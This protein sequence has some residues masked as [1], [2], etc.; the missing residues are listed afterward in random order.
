MPGSLDRACA[1]E[2]KNGRCVLHGDLKTKTMHSF[3]WKFME[4]GGYHFGQLVVQVV[5][6][7]LLSPSDSGMLAIILVFINIGSVLV[8]SGLNTALVQA[9]HINSKD[10]STVFWFSLALAGLLY[11]LLYV[12]AP[13]AALWYGLPQLT[14]ALRVLGLVLFIGAFNSIQIA[15]ASRNLDFRPIFESTSAAVALSGLTGIGMA[16]LGYGYWALIG[17]QLVYGTIA[18]LVLSFKFPWIP[19][20]EFDLARGKQFY[21]YGWKLA[22]SSLLDTAFS[23]LYDLVVG[24]VFSRATLGYFAQ[25]EK[26]PATVNALFDGSIQSVMLSTM[27]KLQDDTKLAK[28]ALRRS[29]SLSTF[30]VVPV[31]A[32]L[33]LTAPSL[34]V[35]VLSA[36]WVDSVPFLQAFCVLYAVQPIHVADGPIL[37]T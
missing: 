37:T 25:G 21:R 31:M 24:K 19:R 12:G 26:F 10:C 8:Q 15:L 22:S 6:A 4:R 14:S 23:G 34:V 18:C 16:Y 36:K 5:L 20:L 11:A 7:R 1:A 30:V 33:L 27:S 9:P 3:F 17:Q 13:I 2:S 32:V 35:F 28:Q 29:M